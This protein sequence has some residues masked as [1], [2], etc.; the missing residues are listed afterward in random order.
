V[1]VHYSSV[2]VT[3]QESTFL[4]CGYLV[5]PVSL[6]EKTKLVPS[7]VLGTIVKNQLT[8]DVHF[9]VP[10]TPD[11][12]FYSIELRLFLYQHHTILLSVFECLVM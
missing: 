10:P 4:V 5:V 2:Y 3:N 6:L 12:H 1:V 11:L 9:G 7:N 8:L